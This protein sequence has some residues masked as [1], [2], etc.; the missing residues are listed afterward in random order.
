[1]SIELMISLKSMSCGASSGTNAIS[2]CV[3]VR[4]GSGEYPVTGLLSDNAMLV[5]ELEEAP[6]PVLTSNR[7][8]AD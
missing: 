4:G 2:G 3:G 8:T 1:M 5:R 7:L 6:S